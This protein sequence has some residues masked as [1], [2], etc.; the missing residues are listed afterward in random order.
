MIKKTDN[1]D[2]EIEGHGDKFTRQ[3]ADALCSL[4]GYKGL[5]AMFTD[6]YAMNGKVI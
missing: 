1:P 3:A 2:C 4:R 5:V 6:S